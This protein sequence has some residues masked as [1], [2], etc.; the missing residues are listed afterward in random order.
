LRLH[1]WYTVEIVSPLAALPLFP[2]QNM[3]SG[4]FALLDDIATLMD[5][6]AVMSKVA[7]KKTAGILG[8]DLAVN[9]EKASGFVSDREL[10]VLWAITKG[11]ALNKLMILPVAFLLSAFAPVAITVILVAGG[12]YLAYEGA[13]K[14][15]AYIFPHPTDKE[16][17]LDLDISEAEVLALEK[18]K[19]KSAITTDFILSVEIVIIAM[20]TVVDKPLLNQIAVVSVIAF[21]ATIG[22][23]GIV[24][25]VVRMDEFGFKLIALNDREDSVSDK[26]GWMLVNALPHFVR[27]I[28]FIGTL[29]LLLVSGGI[30]A[31][32]IPFFH[33]LLPTWPDI[34]KEFLFGLGVG[35]V[36]L[37][38]VLLFQKLRKKSS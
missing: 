11:S 10:P 29:A 31:H 19:I 7:A 6:V 16:E 33:H 25:L 9:A 3:A 36:V 24:A 28:G 1:P 13:E 2:T 17:K 21:I 32:N 38:P 27:G 8:D 30:F 22:V 34:A 37:L 12:L 23:Y 26:I 18:K 15:H 20:S 5:D 14:I 4:L 35:I